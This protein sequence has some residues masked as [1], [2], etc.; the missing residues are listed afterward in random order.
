MYKICMFLV[1][2]ER[3]LNVEHNEWIQNFFSCPL[4]WIIVN[5]C[6]LTKNQDTEKSM[7]MSCPEDFLDSKHKLNKIQLD[8]P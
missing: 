8:C 2:L 7:R 3:D 6:I 5:S 1:G 4:G